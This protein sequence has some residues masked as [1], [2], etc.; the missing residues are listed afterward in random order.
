MYILIFTLLLVI[1]LI[2]FRLANRF[3]IIDK[4]NQRSSHTRITLRGGGVIFYFGV[5]LYAAIYGIRYPWFLL[6]LTFISL[7]SFIDDIKSVSSKVRLL[8]H[9]AAILLLF[10]QW[11]LFIEYPWWYIA[12]A[13]IFCVGI[14]NAYNFMDGI[15]GITGGY[16]LVILSVL[17]YINYFVSPFT[18]QS[19]IYFVLLAVM[20]FNFFNFR[21]NAKCFA[22]DVGSVSIAFIILFFL[23]QLI[24]N[25]GDMSYLI[26][27]AFYGVDS[28]LTIIH[29]IMLHEN[30]FQ[31]HRRHVFQLMAN[32][33]KISHVTVSLIYM[34]GQLLIDVVYLMIE[35]EYK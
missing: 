10:H 17:A 29:R 27:L 25:T 14:I 8:F 15:N 7:I 2:Y 18:S 33:M 23:G 24:L 19:L 16:S 12:I 28:V 13:L 3:N 31:P 20:V 6:G 1:E 35:V 21:T 9:F 30:I 11:G 26:L 32:E 4:P 34:I 5:L 22:G